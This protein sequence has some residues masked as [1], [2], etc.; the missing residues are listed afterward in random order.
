MK[1]AQPGIV[2]ETYQ[3]KVR[4]TLQPHFLCRLQKTN[5]HQVIGHVDAVRLMRKQRMT[6]AKSRFD[7]VVAFKDQVSFDRK[8]LEFQGVAESLRSS[9]SITDCQRT[10]D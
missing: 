7:P 2:V 3:G 8:A 1:H 9:N 6:R 4:R 10:A 5:S